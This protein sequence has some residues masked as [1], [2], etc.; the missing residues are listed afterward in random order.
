MPANKINDPNRK[1]RGLIQKLY[2]VETLPATV[3]EEL[4]YQIMGSTGNVYTVTIST[5]PSCT[6]PDYQTRHNRCK[7]I[8]FVLLRIMQ[9]PDKDTN[10]ITYTK[11]EVI[12]MFSKIPQVTNY[13]CVD[14]KTRDM[15]I[16]LKL[17]QDGSGKTAQKDLDDV[18]PVCLDDLTNGFKLEYCKYG[19]GKNIHAECYSMM[20]KKKD[21]CDMICVF[22]RA[23]W[24]EDPTAKD[25][26]INLTVK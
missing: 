22:C 13:L 5:N 18:C 10:I 25:K 11:Q 24:H 9:V 12:T 23:S 21:K 1:L 16:K 15:Y 17:K 20:N 2:L 14:E 4:S 8:Y 3:P 7:H 19:C 6:C 26:Y